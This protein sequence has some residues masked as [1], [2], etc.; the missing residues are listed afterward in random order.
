[1]YFTTKPFL[2]NTVTKDKTVVCGPE[3][4]F[5][6]CVAMKFVDDDDDDDDDNDDDFSDWN[7]VALLVFQVEPA[8]RRHSHTVSCR[9]RAGRD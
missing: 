6:T 3:V 8:G 2:A 1:M 7:T 5:E 9:D 4:V